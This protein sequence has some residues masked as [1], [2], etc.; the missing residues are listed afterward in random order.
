MDWKRGLL[1]TKDPDAV[2]D[3]FWDFGDWLS[4]GDTI[5]THT[6]VAD[7]GLTVDASTVDGNGVRVWLSGGTV[8]ET[9]TVRVRVVTNQSRTIDR[10][11]DFLIGEK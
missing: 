8:G 10:S 1:L 11:V 3:W 5:A 6:T 2:L 9:Y 4:A 7:A